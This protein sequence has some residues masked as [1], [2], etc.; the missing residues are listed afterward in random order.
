MGKRFNPEEVLCKKRELKK[1]GAAILNRPF[2][3]NKNLKM[4]STHGGLIF[5]CYLS[6]E[7]NTK[8]FGSIRA[9]APWVGPWAAAAARLLPIKFHQVNL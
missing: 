2:E 1:T 4:R 7:A 3:R 8:I 9:M 6:A 5:H